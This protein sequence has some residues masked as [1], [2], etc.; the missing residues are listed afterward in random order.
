[1]KLTEAQQAESDVRYGWCSGGTGW[2]FKWTGSFSIH[3][4]HV[5]YGIFLH[6]ANTLGTTPTPSKKET[7]L[8]QHQHV[9]GQVIYA[10]T[11]CIL[12]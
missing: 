12:T 7:K 5:W 8:S 11:R 6:A 10:C 9:G 1:M 4:A 3:D 2:P